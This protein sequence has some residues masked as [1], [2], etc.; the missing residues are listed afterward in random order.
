MQI[1]VK[2]CLNMLEKGGVAQSRE[3]KMRRRKEGEF[4]S[5][6]FTACSPIGLLA[7]LRASFPEVPRGTGVG[8]RG[9]GPGRACSQDTRLL[10]GCTPYLQY[11]S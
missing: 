1:S 3:K 7:S 2:P 6:N 9:E 4:F 5:L 8:Q 10:A 11:C